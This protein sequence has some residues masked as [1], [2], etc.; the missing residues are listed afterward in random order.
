MFYSNIF[1]LVVCRYEYSRCRRRICSTTLSLL[2]KNRKMQSQ[3]FFWQYCT[4]LNACCIYKCKTDILIPGFLTRINYFI[5]VSISCTFLT[6]PAISL[7]FLYF[8]FRFGFHFF[9]FFLF[10]NWRQKF[11]T[12]IF[13]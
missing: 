10:Y 4:A 1:G 12:P 13:R 6:F 9:F 5:S 7:S 3:A 2:T 11:I 8:C